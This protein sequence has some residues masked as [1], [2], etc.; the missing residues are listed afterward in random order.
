MVGMWGGAQWERERAKTISCW[1]RRRWWRRR[2]QMEMT[3][4][5]KSE[6][7]PW[8]RR[9]LW[10]RTFHRF[11]FLLCVHFYFIYPWE[12]A[13]RFVRS[14]KCVMCVYDGTIAAVSGHTRQKRLL[15]WRAMGEETNATLMEKREI[16]VNLIWRVMPASAIVSGAMHSAEEMLAGCGSY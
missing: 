7:E 16:C 12:D 2:R 13:F 1:W 6:P 11:S 4:W 5:K 10:K 9:S 8:S 14:P 15:H 3:G